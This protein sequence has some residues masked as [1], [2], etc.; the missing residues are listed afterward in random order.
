LHDHQH[1]AQK[2]LVTVIRSIGGQVT[3]CKVLTPPGAIKMPPVPAAQAVNRE[4]TM[5]AIPAETNAVKAASLADAKTT[6][7]SKT[8]AVPDPGPRPAESALSSK[9]AESAPPVNSSPA[10]TNAVVEPNTPIEGTA[11][12]ARKVAAEPSAAATDVPSSPAIPL[13][14]SASSTSPSPG[15]NSEP[16]VPPPVAKNEDQNP[17]ARTEPSFASGQSILAQGVRADAFPESTRPAGSPL[18]GVSAPSAPPRSF[19]R[20]NGKFL[21]LI[22]AAVLAAAFCFYNWFKTFAG[23]SGK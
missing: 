5:A 23:R 16:Q 8:V 20:E 7:P 18:L 17:T 3:D 22:L 13:P 10:E 6:E 19:L 15:T 21:L 14:A 2:P 11:G 12:S 9:P 4:V 1:Q